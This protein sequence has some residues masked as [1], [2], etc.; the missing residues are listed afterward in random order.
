MNKGIEIRAVNCFHLDRSLGLYIEQ[1][2]DRK[3]FF[4]KPIVMEESAREPYEPVE[5]LLH[6][7]REMGQQ[8]MD[9]LWQCG[10]RPS[11]GSGSAG[12]LASVQG[13]LADMRQIAFGKLKIEKP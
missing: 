8:L 1:V 12:Q 10:L 13:H 2:Q 7:S 11:E 4:A 6:I 3:I 9:D 5:P